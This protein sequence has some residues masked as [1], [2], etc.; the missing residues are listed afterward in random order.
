M[1]AESS[2][3]QTAT[4]A[5]PSGLYPRLLGAA[6]NE[7]A[8][9]VQTLHS[10]Q[11]SVARVGLFRVRRGERRLARFLA[12][13][14][15]LPAVGET[16]STRLEITTDSERETWRRNFAGTQV[17]TRHRESP[18]GVLA[19]RF[20]CLELRYRLS[21]VE[22]ALRFQQVGASFCLGQLAMPLPRWLAPQV[23]AR[24]WAETNSAAV[25]VAVRAS[26]PLAGLLVAYEGS[27]ESEELK[28]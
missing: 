26:F 9:P 8:A 7:L 18:V 2:F 11:G 6:W 1:A 21:V 14:G 10:S 17:V 13:L 24:A 15:R 19:E 20:R 27:M 16:V 12:W 4:T 22:H 28:P 25:Q 3:N 23:A 5:P